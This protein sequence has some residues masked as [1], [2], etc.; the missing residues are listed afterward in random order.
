MDDEIFQKEISMCKELFR[1]NRGKCHWG[2]CDK[3][4]VILLLHKL[5]H[6]E[7]I[8]DE[9]EVKKFRSNILNGD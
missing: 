3:C 8:E 2:E 1:K 6:G 5:Y 9:K 7:V 4:G